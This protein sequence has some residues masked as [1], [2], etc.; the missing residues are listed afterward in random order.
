MANRFEIMDKCAKNDLAR[1]EELL[2]AGVD[3]NQT[4]VDQGNTPLHFAATNGA[5]Q[6]MEFLVK[7]GAEI[8]VQNKRGVTPLHTLVSKRYDAL[9]LWLVK[10]GASLELE[11]R[12][13]FTAK[14]L[15]L[16]WFQKELEEVASG[17]LFGGDDGAA[18]GGSG[19]SAAAAPAEPV[20][21]DAS[22]SEEVLQIHLDSGGKKAIKINSMMTGEDLCRVMAGKMNMQPSMAQH[23]TSYE[24]KRGREKLIGPAD[25]LY[26]IKRRWPMIIGKSGNETNLHCF[27]KIRAKAGAPAEVKQ[28]IAQHT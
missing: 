13:G 17:K 18:G 24:V 21:S 28:E 26:D 8:N 20:P 22:Y 27:F 25:N 5:K 7:R 2:D 19:A 12:R 6:V 11:D 1:V 16:D 4:D 14:D 15:A 23:L 10:Q 9:A 3:P